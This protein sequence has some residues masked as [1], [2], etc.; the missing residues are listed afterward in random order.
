MCT[1]TRKN[2]FTVNVFFNRHLSL[3]L[4][5][6][7]IFIH[8]LLSQFLSIYKLMMKHMREKERGYTQQAHECTVHLIKLNI[9]MW[10]RFLSTRTR[11]CSK[12]LISLDEITFSSLLHNSQ[13]PCVV[14]RVG[15]C[16]VVRM[17]NLSNYSNKIMMIHVTK[18]LVSSINNVLHCGDVI[19]SNTLF[20]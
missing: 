19:T 16:R 6:W 2:T 17:R 5:K 18:L 8:L 15:A 3:D 10:S 14:A 1:C 12:L 7:H 11:S 4:K 9:A 13:C 20:L